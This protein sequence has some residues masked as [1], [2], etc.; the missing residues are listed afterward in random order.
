MLEA[1]LGAMMLEDPHRAVPLFDQ[2]IGSDLNGASSETLHQYGIA[3]AWVGRIDDAER[4][5]RL[6][7]E[8]SPNAYLAYRFGS[9]LAEQRKFS[10]ASAVFASI[11]NSEPWM[12][13]GSM[14]SICFPRR[15][16]SVPPMSRFGEWWMASLTDPLAIAISFISSPPT[17]AM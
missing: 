8:K 5:L 7:F 4:A 6:A 15:M 9:V 16:I 14:R 17:R 3:L 11:E 10:E 1:A 2:A 12:A 13:G